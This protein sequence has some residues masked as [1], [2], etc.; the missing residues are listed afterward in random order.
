MHKNNMQTGQKATKDRPRPQPLSTLIKDLYKLNN[1]Y[2]E[3]FRRLYLK[4]ADHRL[5]VADIWLTATVRA[6]M[7]H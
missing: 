2:W 7:T 5:T 4:N 6:S 3:Y 1:L